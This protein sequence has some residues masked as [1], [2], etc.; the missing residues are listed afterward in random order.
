[1][2][3]NLQRACYYESFHFSV[4]L[5]S[6]GTH[7]LLMYGFVPRPSRFESWWLLAPEAVQI[8]HD[9]WQTPHSGSH[10]YK[11]MRKNQWML[12]FLW[13]WNKTRHGN[14]AERVKDLMGK[15]A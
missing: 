14:I 8:I 7:H 6:E 4:R 11:L 12:K 1:M 5:Q 13:F 9:Q 2:D 15:L 10:M 3:G